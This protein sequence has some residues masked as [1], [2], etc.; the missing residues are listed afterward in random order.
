MTHIRYVPSPPLT[1]YID[2]LYYLDGRMPY[3]HETILPLPVLD[4]KIN[5]GGAFKVYENGHADTFTEG[6]CVG[7]WKVPHMLDWPHDLR[8]FGVRFKPDGAYP[9]L[10]VSLSELR[11]R[12]VT[13]DAMWG[14]AAGELRERL[15]AAPTI[16]AGFRLLEQF[17]QD[18]L[19]EAPPGLNVVR[20]G[21]TQVEQCHGVLSIRDLS[22]QIGISQ[23][24]LGRQFQRFVGVSVKELARLYRFETILNMLDPTQPVEWT[25]IAHQTGYYDQS[26]LNKDFLAFTG[27]NPTD[28]LQFR[29]RTYLENPEHARTHLRQL[30]ID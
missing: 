14:R 30:A 21:T 29:R 11:N 16:Q 20:Y 2:Y 5:L 27:H 18:H 13:L 8:L 10:Q 28:Y 4:L 9:F 26:H 6:W 19:S 15:Y 12:V 22:D 23:N 1:F 17:L 25:R 3:V 7:L 24:Q